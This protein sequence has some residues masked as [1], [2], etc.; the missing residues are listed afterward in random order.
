MYIIVLKYLGRKGPLAPNY[1]LKVLGMPF[2]WLGYAIGPPS[3][4]LSIGPMGKNDIVPFWVNDI[5]VDRAH[6]ENYS[7]PFW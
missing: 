7:A 2:G 5:F 6:G 1:P 3:D 4:I